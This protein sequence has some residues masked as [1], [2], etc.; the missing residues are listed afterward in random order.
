MSSHDPLFKSQLHSP[1]REVRSVK[2]AV[3][4]AFTAWLILMTIRYGHS[5]LRSIATSF[6]PGMDV[7]WF[8]LWLIVAVIIAIC[9]AAWSGILRVVSWV[10]LLAI[11]TISVLSGAFLA[12]LL[13]SLLVVVAYG[14]GQWLLRLAGVERQ[15]FIESIAIAVP[16]GLVIPAMGGFVLACLHWFNA[17]SL[18]LL[19][20]V[21]TLVQL[22]TILRLKDSRV[23]VGKFP[24]DITLPILLTLPVVVL[25]FVWAVAPEIQFDA[26]N[27]HL[28][29]PNIYL[30]NGGFVNLPYFF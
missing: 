11:V 4:A 29:V 6:I 26:N 2:K 9:L 12:A 13:A 21:L 8:A 16:L 1:T 25:N 15:G 7:E 20:L 19:L 5:V 22:K 27:Y 3:E 18:S 24:A 30:A 14:W 17:T 23:A 10:A 28:A